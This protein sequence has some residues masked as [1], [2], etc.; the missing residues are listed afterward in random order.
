MPPSLGQSV[1][2]VPL[3][4]EPAQS[5]VAAAAGRPVGEA[6]VSPVPY[7]QGFRAATVVGF[8]GQPA[9][10]RVALL[11]YKQPGD[12]FRGNEDTFVQRLGDVPFSERG[13]PGTWT[14]I[15]GATAPAKT[16]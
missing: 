16:K 7:P 2:Y 6:I 4:S 12:P 9:E 1:L 11:V 10:R 13:V 14:H 5:F 3:V 8:A 15:H